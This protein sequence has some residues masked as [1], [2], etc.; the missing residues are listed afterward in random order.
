MAEQLEESCP[1]GVDFVFDNVGGSILD[2]LLLKINPNARIVICGAISQYSGKLNQGLVQ[3]P[4]NY[5]K[6]AE[7]GATMKGFTVMQYIQKLPR[8]LFKLYWLHLRGKVN[9]KEHV[10]EGIESFPTALNHLF[11]GVSIGKCLVTLNSSGKDLYAA[12]L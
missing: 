7:R 10:E 11:T 6:L 9:M 1:D 12:R 4:S 2:D 5:L 8:A 3:G